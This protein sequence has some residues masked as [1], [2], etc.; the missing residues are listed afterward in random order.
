MLS[1]RF[2][3][4]NAIS[5]HAA[6]HLGFSNTRRVLYLRTRQH[7]QINRKV[8]RRLSPI[9]AAKSNPTRAPPP[10]TNRTEDLPAA[11][12]TRRIADSLTDTALYSLLRS[13][14]ATLNPIHL[15]AATKALRRLKASKESSLSAQLVVS[16]MTTDSAPSRLLLACPPRELS[17]IAWAC[18]QVF[19]QPGLI[20]SVIG[21]AAKKVLNTNHSELAPQGLCNLFWA[22][23]S[24]SCSEEEE[25]LS[26]LSLSLEYRLTTSGSDCLSAQDISMLLWSMARL[27]YLPSTSIVKNLSLRAMSIMEASKDQPSLI[28]TQ[29]LSN[30]VWAAGSL[31]RLCLD[32]HHNCS[33]RLNSFKLV[34]VRASESTL[35]YN[36][37]LIETSALMSGLTLI[38]QSI[39]VDDLYFPALQTSFKDHLVSLS[40]SLMSRCRTVN[41]SMGPLASIT[42]SLVPLTSAI[43]S[44]AIEAW[45][46]ALLDF[47]SR[48]QSVEF[49][50]ADATECSTVLWALCRVLSDMRPSI[51]IDTTAAQFVLSRLMNR[52]MSVDFESSSSK[53]AI[54]KVAWSCEMNIYPLH[55]APLAHKDPLYLINDN[56]TL[57]FL[58]KALPTLLM[59]SIDGSTLGLFASVLWALSHR[60]ERIKETLHGSRVK[61]NPR[62]LHS[63]ELDEGWGIITSKV[64]L[65]TVIHQ[66]GLSRLTRRV[67][68][69]VV[70]KIQEMLLQSDL[71]DPSNNHQNNVAALST[72][73]SRW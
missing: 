65:T 43:A 1:S 12:L 50:Y 51:S 32:P 47:L 10:R 16:L 38:I 59:D 67:L 7:L 11:L 35:G 56:D 34:V 29:G 24:W 71:H 57:A 41:E 64:N 20:S 73:C 68:K 17:S 25:L 19:P 37:K 52:F 8:L 60:L 3:T 54:A 63:N 6:C 58:N 49:A 39:G 40:T 55:K 5:L 46:I 72:S 14:H 26:L 2:S 28:S 36:F 31:S 61:S 30:I 66:R 69:T 21:M 48:A 23:A 22:F 33:T 27:S 4:A 45:V 70:N 9:L 42:S 62:V 13:H 44:E 15:A 18:T 53:K